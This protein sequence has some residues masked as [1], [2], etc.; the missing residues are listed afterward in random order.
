MHAPIMFLHHSRTVL[1]IIL[2]DGSLDHI[3]IIGT[4]KQNDH[5]KSTT[6]PMLLIGVGLPPVSHDLVNRNQSGNL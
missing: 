3:A 5:D 1:G 2:G 6:P 4:K